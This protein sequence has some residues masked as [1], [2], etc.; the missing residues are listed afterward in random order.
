[1]KKGAIILCAF[2]L[3]ILVISLAAAYVE[4]P[5][6]SPGIFERPAEGIVPKL[7]QQGSLINSAMLFLF[8]SSYA[9]TGTAFIVWFAVWLVIFVFI[10]DT[11]ATFSALS[12][13]AAWL[14]GAGMSVVATSLGLITFIVKWLLGLTAA[15]GALS[16]F[17]VAGT[18]FAASVAI[19]LGIFGKFSRWAMARQA[20]LKEAKIIKSAV[21]AKQAIT[22][23]REIQQAFR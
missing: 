11:L 8:G 2:I 7:L 16:L 19:H 1:M 5:A 18:A 15:F 22:N 9:D 10:S 12:T 21:E 20:M 4:A 3:S 23:L 6:P 17:I 14:I 13:W